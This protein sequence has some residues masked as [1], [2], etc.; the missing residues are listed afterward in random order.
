MIL[1]GRSFFTLFGKIQWSRLRGWQKIGLG[2]VYLCIIIMPAIYL[3]LAIQYFLRTRRQTL[4]QTFG[5]WYRSKSGTSRVTIGIVS[6]IFILT[7]A[8][9]TAAGAS[10]HRTNAFLVLTPTVTPQQIVQSN[11]P[12]ATTSSQD[13]GTT[14]T[15]ATT[16]TTIP[17]V[18]TTPKPSSV[19]TRA[20]QPTPKPT[21]P[22][23]CQAVN[24][25]PW[26]YNFTPGNYITSPP[27][28]FCAYF[29]CIASFWNG[30]D[31]IEECQ[32]GEYSLSGGIQG[33]CSHHGGNLQ[34]L[35]SH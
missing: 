34:P 14:V 7:F 13:S 22:P 2:L 6:L 10:Y 15:V 12:T 23:A 29:S 20:L 9:F 5:N 17:A 25:N 27:S 31:H 4:G 8:G 3:F 32:D 21:Q 26:C 11:N 28:D 35:Y 33:S 24:G 18:T 16:P 30:H 1:D 19:A